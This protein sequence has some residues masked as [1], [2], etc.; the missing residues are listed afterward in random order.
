MVGH[1]VKTAIGNLTTPYGVEIRSTMYT[2][3]GITCVHNNDS[4]KETMYVYTYVWLGSHS[5]F[6]K[7][8]RGR[9][10]EL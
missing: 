10:S 8:E 1:L 9:V 5:C 4:A 7:S 2:H 6:K 3:A